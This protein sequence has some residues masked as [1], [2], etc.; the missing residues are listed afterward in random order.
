MAALPELCVFDL[1]DCVW[2]P[3]MFTLRHTPTPEDVLL[4][5]LPGGCGTG[6]VGLRSGPRDVI[7]LFPGAIVAF[8]RAMRGQYGHMRLAAASSADTPRAC[9]LY[10]SPS[11][12][13][14]TRSRMPSSA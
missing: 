6:V 8:Q 4:G 7:R 3:E 11:P 2:S 5:P 1:D 9:L 14:R 13:D 10:T 12:R